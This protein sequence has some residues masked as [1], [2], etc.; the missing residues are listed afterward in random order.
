MNVTEQLKLQV[1]GDRFIEEEVGKDQGFFHIN[2]QGDLLRIIY[3]AK[4]DFLDIE[5]S[6]NYFI[7]CLN[8]HDFISTIYDYN[9]YGFS[10]RKCSLAENAHFF[11]KDENDEL[12]HVT[13]AEMNLI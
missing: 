7:R 12:I 2:F 10:L 13:F 8:K 6:I 3:R 5:Y 1:I 9:R 11:R 4:S